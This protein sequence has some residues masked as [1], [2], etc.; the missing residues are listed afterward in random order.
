MDLQHAVIT[1]PQR[2]CKYA[3]M[4][5]ASIGKWEATYKKYLLRNGKELDEEMK[6]NIVMRYLPEEFERTLRMQL[7]LTGA[8]T[9]FSVIRQQIMDMCVSQSGGILPTGMDLNN[10]QGANTEAAADS[11]KWTAD[12]W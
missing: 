2:R 6:T 9:Q 1:P 11:E 5:P 12:E 7:Q 8:S 3:T 4:V 10:L